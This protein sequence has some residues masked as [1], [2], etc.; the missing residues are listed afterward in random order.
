MA[1]Q[2]ESESGARR[3]TYAVG[4]IHGRLDL[5]RSA[6]ESIVAHA[7]GRRFRIVFLGDYVD[8]GPESRGVV[9]FLIDLQ[10]RWP[11]VCLKGNH[12]DLMNRAVTEPDAAKMRRWLDNGGAYALRSYGLEPDGDPATSVPSEHIRWLAGLPLTTGDAYRIFVHAG[13]LP[14]KPMHRQAEQTCLWIREP[15]L[16][17][18]P[19][20]F[21][22]HIVHGHTPV[23]AGKR[24]AGEPELLEHRTNLDT[25]A[26]A[27]G[28]L[29]VG[30]FDAQVRGGPIEVIKI[31]GEPMLEL[32]PTLLDL[33][34]P[35]D[36]EVG[37]WWRRW[38]ES[39]L[40]RSRENQ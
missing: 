2:D 26:F 30:V 16:S 4:D 13:L 27:T 34:A 3:Y 23:W 29:C 7:A 15:F 18:R 12:E 9:E 31:R 8:R 40:S 21:E 33:G 19:G 39:R 1:D 37:R 25:A 11:I 20:D 38:V 28:V 35:K 32:M 14:R 6:V 5:L 17:A 10:R 36:H 22:A 24:D